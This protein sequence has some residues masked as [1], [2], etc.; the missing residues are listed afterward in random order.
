VTVPEPTPK[1]SREFRE[2]LAESHTR[3]ATYL[4]GVHAADVAEWLQDIDE[5]DA[6]RVFALLGAEAQADLLDYAEDELRLELVQR[7]SADDLAEVLDELPSDRAVDVLA[8]ADQRVA[9]D[10]L[11]SIEP[12]TAEELRQLSAYDAETAGGI[13]ATEFATVP[14]GSHLTDAI[15]AIKRL[16][17]D[18][19]QEV[20]VFVIDEQGAPV[21]YISDRAILANTIHE[22]VADVMVQPFTVAATADQE[23]ASLV[24]DK[25][26]LMALGVVG[27]SGELIGVI[28]AE[29][30]ADVMGDEADEDIQRLI[31]TKPGAQQTRLPI[32]VR[33]RQRLPLMGLTVLGGF[34][35]A[36]IL[37]L[38]LPNQGGPP[39]GGADVLRYL[40]LIIGLAGN[41]GVQSSTI[42][43]R[44]FATGE[45]ERERELSVF[46]A[47]VAVGALIGLICGGMTTILAGWVEVGGVLGA[48][49][50]ALGASIAVAV[51]WTAIIGCIVPMGCRRLGIDP[52]IVA[53]PFLICLSDISGSVIYIL[54][55]KALLPEFG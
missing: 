44:A 48:F 29:D 2:E 7:M 25:Y 42:L 45:V 6:W 36:R 41:V 35:S 23:D 21:G 26:S 49:G 54:M 20:G 17:E 55:A 51:A 1:T 52:A 47:E 19:E 18:A 40:P 43:V 24:V 30:A 38:L 31:G 3:A 53:G 5:E 33:V 14:V 27:P 32:L 8:D 10:V 15:K 37:G 11:R 39:G 28:S 12:K 9:E 46:G 50:A 16:G 4:A 34:A 13:M 22:P